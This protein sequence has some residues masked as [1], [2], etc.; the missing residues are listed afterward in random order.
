MADCCGARRCTCT[1]VAGPGVEIDGGGSTTNPYVISAPGGSGGTPTVIQAGDTD[2]VDTT[3]TGAG[4]TADPVVVS[5]AV[6]LDATPPGG[7]TNLIQTGP[8]GLYAELATACGLT[9]AGTTASPLAAAVQNWPY[10]CDVDIFGGV[11]ACGSDGVLRGE[12]RGKATLVQRGQSRAYDIL[13]PSGDT[14]NTVADT[15]SATFTNPDTCRDAFVF[16]VIEW[17]VWFE[18][19]PGS[20]AAAGVTGDETQH[21][22]N[23][24][25]STMNQFHVQQMKFLG[26]NPAVVGPG[27]D[28]TASMS[29]LVGQGVGGARY[30]HIQSI[31][32]VLF[33]SI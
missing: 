18:L 21:V 3:V 16:Q 17:D 19:P 28:Y 8:D 31:I 25:S 9:G 13:V 10:P 23:T 14:A 32:R 30:T 11:I 2:T 27:A 29:V 15:F 4:T 24:G 33:L 1:L 26:A 12:P 6:R 20:G 5:S 22:Y 7:G